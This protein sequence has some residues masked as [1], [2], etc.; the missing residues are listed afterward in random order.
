[1]TSRDVKAGE[2][3]LVSKALD[4]L[5]AVEVENDEKAMVYDATRAL[6]GESEGWK[7]TKKIALKISQNPSLSE[8]VQKLTTRSERL[9][10]GRT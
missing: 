8:D 9:P 6:L 1:M 2:L 3:L 4:V 7:L 5:F 10:R